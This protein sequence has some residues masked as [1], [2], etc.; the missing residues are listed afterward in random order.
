MPRFAQVD[1]GVVTGILSAKE[2]PL[3]KKKDDGGHELP[4]GRVFVPIGDEADVDGGDL[5]NASINAFAKPVKLPPPRVH[6]VEEVYVLLEAV[7][8]KV[9]VTLP[10]NAEK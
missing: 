9:G 7:A 2:A 5:Y 6:T 8:A 1:N 4:P 3:G 10:L